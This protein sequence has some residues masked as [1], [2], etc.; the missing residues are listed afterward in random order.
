MTDYVRGSTI[1]IAG[2]FLDKNGDPATVA[3]AELTL[4]Y[5]SVAGSK[6]VDVVA[7]SEVGESWSY[8]WDSSVARKGTVAYSMKATGGGEVIVKDGEIT[9]TANAANG[10]TE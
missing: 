7:M 5:T 4:K 3:S 6:V 10:A 2:S 8:D 9:L 1:T